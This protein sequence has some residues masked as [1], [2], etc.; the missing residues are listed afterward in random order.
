MI[1]N[2]KGQEEMVGFALIIILVA[3]AMLFFLGFYVRSD[4]TEGAESYEA[5]SF[6]QTSLQYTTE[7]GNFLGR[8]D[9][10]RLLSECADNSLCGDGKDSCDVLNSTLKELV[11]SSW[12]VGPDR[13]IRGYDFVVNSGGRELIFLKGGNETGNF[14]GSSQVLP[15]G[16]EIFFRAYYIN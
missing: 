15:E 7:C 13:P 8:F 5:E 12:N 16:I 4:R 2:K 14:R 11:D 9:V 10:Q 1:K 6:I 3:I